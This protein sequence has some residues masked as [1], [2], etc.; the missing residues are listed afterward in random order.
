VELGVGALLWAI[1][2]AGADVRPE[3]VAGSLP[4]GL[5]RSAP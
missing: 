2:L 1:D 3:V 4:A 5:F